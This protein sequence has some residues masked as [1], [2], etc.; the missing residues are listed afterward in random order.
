M[1]WLPTRLEVAIV[2]AYETG[3]FAEHL[4]GW[5]AVLVGIGGILVTARLA[6]PM[7]RAERAIA[8]VLALRDRPDRA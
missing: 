1:R 6:R 7:L 4:D 5:P 2:A 3:V 8:A